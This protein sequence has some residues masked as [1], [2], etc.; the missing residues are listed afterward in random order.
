MPPPEARYI[1]EPCPPPGDEPLVPTDAF[2]HG[3]T[4]DAPLPNA[5]ESLGLDPAWLPRLPKKSSPSLL[6]SDGTLKQRWGIHIIEGPDWVMF[7]IINIFMVTMS[8]IAA[9]LWTLYK[10]GF[11]GAFTFAAWILMVVNA[12]MLGYIAKWNGA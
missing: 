9:F 10:H 6:V 3:I 7:V 12:V 1:Y 2:P 11:S 5:N 8:G 4:C